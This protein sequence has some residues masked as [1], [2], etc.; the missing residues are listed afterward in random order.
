LNEGA[1]IFFVLF[2]ISRYST[3]HTICGSTNVAPLTLASSGSSLGGA[4]RF[5]GSSA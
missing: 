4:E 1:R 5:S 2:V 3:S